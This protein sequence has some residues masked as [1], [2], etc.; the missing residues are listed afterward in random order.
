MC[1]WFILC[2]C[3]F[4]LDC[5]LDCLLDCLVACLCLF[6]FDG[7]CVFRFVRLFVCLCV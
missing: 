7:L 2:V 1:D 6:F 5:V 4:L 3:V